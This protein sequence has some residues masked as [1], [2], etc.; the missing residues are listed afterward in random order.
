MEQ[1]SYFYETR[2][3]WAGKR[4][5]ALRSEGLPELTVSTPPEFHG[6]AG[7]WSPEHL[8]VAAAEACLMATFLAVAE[9]SR[10]RVAQYRSVAR[11]RLE[12]VADAGLLFT[13]IQ[14]VP[15]VEMESVEDIERGRRIMEKAAKNCLI[16]N[17]IGAR[18]VV[19]PIFSVKKM[20]SAA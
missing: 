11:G 15:A 3:E 16:A 4:R 14:I 6:E 12:P 8:F 10:L 20:E 2:I 19:E 9:K 5:G 17:S 7:F 1:Q 18:V 13:E